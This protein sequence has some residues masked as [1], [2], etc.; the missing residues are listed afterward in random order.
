MK[1]L[2]SGPHLSNRILLHERDARIA[3]GLKHLQVALSIQNYSNA[4]NEWSL[5]NQSG[6]NTFGGEIIVPHA[7]SRLSR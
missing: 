2:S 5:P 7:S 6:V 3:E 4:F 1:E